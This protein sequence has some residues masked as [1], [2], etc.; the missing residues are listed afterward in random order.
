MS[1][2]SLR[3]ASRLLVR[4]NALRTSHGKTIPESTIWGGYSLWS[5]RQYSLYVALAT[6]LDGQGAGL[7]MPSR[8]GPAITARWAIRIRQVVAQLVTLL[9]I[10][11]LAVSRG[12]VLFFDLERHDPISHGSSRLRKAYALVNAGGFTQGMVVHTL[13]DKDFWLFLRRVRYP[14]IYAESVHVWARMLSRISGGSSIAIDDW[15]EIPQNIRPIIQRDLDRI[16]SSIWSARLFAGIGRF[17]GI[18]EF[19]AYDDIRHTAEMLIGF[20]AAH[21]KTVVVQHSNFGYFAGLDVMPPEL[22][23]FPDFFCVA[24]VYWRDRLPQLSSLFAYYRE[25]LRVTGWL[26]A[27]LPGHFREQ[28]VVSAER[29]ILIPYELLS[30]YHPVQQVMTALISNGYTMVFKV[31]PGTPLEAQLNPYDITKN[32][33]GIVLAE[34]LD[35]EMMNSIGAAIGVYSTLLDEMILSGVPVGMIRS[36]FPMFDDKVASGIASP[37]DPDGEVIAD[38][39]ALCALPHDERK[40]RSVIYGDTGSDAELA[41][42]EI[43][44]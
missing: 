31:K 35:D 9:S 43:F 28:V 42:R 32:M 12:R 34:K 29:R 6:A 38:I 5:G 15:H 40:R 44:Q 13:F 27:Q 24:S 1:D 8:S 33:P 30:D 2:E 19:V 7:A 21:V 17:A 23:I 39:R 26:G 22:S 10:V 16:P 20:Y 25:R 11:W 14:V 41:M 37:I 18:R 36:E 3:S 4:I